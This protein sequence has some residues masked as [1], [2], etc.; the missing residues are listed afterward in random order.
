MVECND[1]EG[2][3]TGPNL[4]STPLN[5]QQQFRINKSMKLKTVFLLILKKDN[6]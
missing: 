4:S 6:E 1:H 3:N 2:P 5:Y